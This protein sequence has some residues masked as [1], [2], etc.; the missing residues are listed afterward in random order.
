[1][2]TIDY[3]L[4]SVTAIIV[5]Y[6]SGPYAVECIN[7]L[8]AQSYN[9]LEIIVV[10]N[11]SGDGSV[12]LLKE[13]FGEAIT[14]IESPSNLGFGQANN[15][16][17]AHAHNDYLL[18]VNPDARV[19]GTDFISTLL[20]F[21]MNNPQVG[22][23]GPEI[24][25]PS[26]K[27]FVLP[28]KRYPSQS[29]LK[30]QAAFE[31]LPGP[32]A[33]IL[34]ACLCIEKKMFEQIGGFDPDF[35]LYGEDTDICLRI[36]KLGYE[37]GYCLDAKITHIGG[38]SEFSSV[39]LD[40]YLRKKRGF[41]LFCRKHYDPADVRRIALKSLVTTYFSSM[42]IWMRKWMPRKSM[43]RLENEAQRNRATRIVIR[44]IL[45]S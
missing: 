23:V 38:A 35:F 41:F 14:L 44:E 6:K 19:V 27:K 39:P 26:K 13:T 2:S 37:V 43:E 1:M 36:R 30:D 28:K 25:E 11:A 7:S 10:D 24:H 42:G 9:S 15:M 8:I 33:W 5:N 31:S 18:L 32:Y 4:P 12:D 45:G 34:G 17:A 20:L 16:A 3:R 22:I 40:K 29:R 21:L